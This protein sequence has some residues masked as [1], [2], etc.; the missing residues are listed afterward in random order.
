MRVEVSPAFEV[1][2]KVMNEKYG[3]TA[4]LLSVP[5]DSSESN[6]KVISAYIADQMKGE[7]KRKYIVVGYSKGTPDLQVALATA[8]R[9]EGQRGRVH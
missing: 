6:A 7:D 2:R 4:E 5:N 9:V 8:R 1:G 3:I